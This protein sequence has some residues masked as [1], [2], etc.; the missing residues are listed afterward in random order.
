MSEER[1]EQ[2]FREQEVLHAL[3]RLLQALNEVMSA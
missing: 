3:I 2:E 1:G